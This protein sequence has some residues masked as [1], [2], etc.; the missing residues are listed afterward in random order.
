[1]TV[2]ERINLCKLAERI[3][4]NKEFAKSIGVTNESRFKGISNKDLA[5]KYKKYK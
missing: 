4:K 5:D 3:D 1:M 2:K